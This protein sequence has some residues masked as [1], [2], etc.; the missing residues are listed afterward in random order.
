MGKDLS[1]IGGEKRSQF[2]FSKDKN[3][4]YADIPLYTDIPLSIGAYSKMC[5]GNDLCCIRCERIMECL[6]KFNYKH[7]RI[8]MLNG[9]YRKCSHIID[10]LKEKGLI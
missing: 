4:C 1:F 2:D 9:V 5:S 7:D 6:K 3:P 10:F 8:C